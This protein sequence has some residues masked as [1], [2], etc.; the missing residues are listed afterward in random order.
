MSMPFPF[1]L[2]SHVYHFFPQVATKSSLWDMGLQIFR[3]HLSRRQEIVRKS[4]QGLLALIE[5]E[6][7]GD[8]VSST[9][10]LTR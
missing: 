1:S 5:A 10:D 9:S 2:F 3:A 7:S 8:Q 6:R 4:V